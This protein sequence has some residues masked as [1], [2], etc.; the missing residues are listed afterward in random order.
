MA[1]CGNRAPFE[2]PLPPK[3]SK[4]LR[5]GATDF[6]GRPAASDSPFLYASRG[7]RD[8]IDPLVFSVPAE[9]EL[10]G[11]YAYWVGGIHCLLG[12]RQ[13][14]L[15][16]L[17]RAVEMGNHN[18]PWFQRDKNWDKLR[19]DPEYQRVMEDVRKKW[20]HYRELFDKR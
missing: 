7:Q 10:D 9:K 2:R 17:R 15:T 12:D 3:G 18:Y 11:D 16:Y 4:W 6:G 13:Q 20:E 14:A 1:L 5:R 19:S 8:K